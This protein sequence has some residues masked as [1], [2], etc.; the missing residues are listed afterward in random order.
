[1]RRTHRESGVMIYSAL[2]LAGFRCIWITLSGNSYTAIDDTPAKR[3]NF[4]KWLRSVAKEIEE[5]S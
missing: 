5:R 1:M 2:S 4:A 3:R